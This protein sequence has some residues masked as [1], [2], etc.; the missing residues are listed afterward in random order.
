MFA[1][2]AHWI[3][4]FI[5]RVVVTLTCV[6]TIHNLVNNYGYRVDFSA[7]LLAAVCAIVAMRM[8]SPSCQCQKEKGK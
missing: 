4:W 8:W 5:G 6:W 7:L 1:W 3:G 2:M